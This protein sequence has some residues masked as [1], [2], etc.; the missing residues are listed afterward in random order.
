MK[1]FLWKLHRE[2]REN[3]PQ[4]IM[5]SRWVHTKKLIESVDLA[6]AMALD[7]VL[8]DKAQRCCK[9]Q[10]RFVAKGFSDPDALEV[11]TSPP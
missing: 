9:A 3:A 1:F 2:V 7:E 10:S 5:K 11:P 8:D 6:D 4:R